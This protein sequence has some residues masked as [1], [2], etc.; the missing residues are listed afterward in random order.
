MPLDLAACRRALDATTPAIGGRVTHVKGQTVEAVLPGAKTGSMFRISSAGGEDGVLAEV[1]GFR[2]RE[3]VLAPFDDARG[4]APGDPVLPEGSCDEQSVSSSYLGRVVD[5]LGAPMDEGGPIRKGP[6]IPLY[7]SPPNPLSRS[8]IDCPLWTGVSV[9]D[10]MTTVGRGQRLGIFAGPG[11]GK[12]TL[13]GMLARFC[14]AEIN[15]IALIG[16]R[17]REVPEF[18]REELGPEGLKKSVVVVATGDRAPILRVRAALLATS[19]AEYFRSLGHH[20][21]LMM[22][23]LTRLAHA[24]REIGLAAGEPPAKQGYPPS[25][26]S[27]LPRVL[28]RAGN[29]EDD[30]TLTA[31][32]TV[33]VD[34]DDFTEP[35]SDAARGILDGHLILS[36]TIAE[37]GRYPAVDIL[38]SL[39]RVAHSLVDSEHAKTAREVRRVMSKY[40]ANIDLIQVG[41]HGDSQDQELHR[42]IQLRPRLADVFHQDRHQRRSLEHTLGALKTVL[43]P[44][45]AP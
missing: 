41:M 30:G 35:V 28:E 12:S 33:L 15:I 45:K 6:C 1:I 8:P 17:G 13:M 26:F 38:G 4:I 27:T 5:A 3:T 36:R 40:E 2:E 19:L 43:G 14:E 18:I 11:V 42:A 10:A 37:G 39:S 7:R 29:A 25:V 34:G 44:E 32:Y 31:F 22:D 23:S 16:E 9:L 24:L 21:L 20:V